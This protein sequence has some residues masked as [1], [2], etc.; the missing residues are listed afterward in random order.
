MSLTDLKSQARE[1]HLARFPDHP[2]DIATPSHMAR[3][4]LEH[5]ITSWKTSDFTHAI[6]RIADQAFVC[7]TSLIKSLSWLKP[8]PANYVFR[9]VVRWRYW[10]GAFTVLLLS[11][12]ATWSILHSPKSSSR[13][14]KQSRCRQILGPVSA[15]QDFPLPYP[16]DESAHVPVL[17]RIHWLDTEE[18]ISQLRKESDSIHMITAEV[19][20]EGRRL[21]EYLAIPRPTRI[22]SDLETAIKSL[23]E[24]LLSMAD[25]IILSNATY[26]SLQ[27]VYQAQISN[28]AKELQKHNSTWWHELGT[29]AVGYQSFGSQILLGDL[30][31]KIGKPRRQI[32]GTLD[33]AR[34]GLTAV[35]QALRRLQQLLV[36][37][38]K[39]VQLMDTLNML[40]AYEGAECNSR[41]RQ[42]LVQQWLRQDVVGN[43]ALVTIWDE[44]SGSITL[45]EQ[46]L[47]IGISDALCDRGEGITQRQVLP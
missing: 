38:R 41:C 32:S 8:S 46:W 37:V 39:L 5:T 34:L 42:E 21:I 36:L 28:A 16:M 22:A 11:C 47:P 29:K 26:I 45:G 14:L 9:A 24:L 30:D 33:D 10:L 35:R 19:L 18:Y 7:V 27:L 12:F 3:T 20:I 1:R 6:V 2:D 40:F 13:E 25:S 17:D 43:T 31:E 15:I 23:R 4:Y 44:I